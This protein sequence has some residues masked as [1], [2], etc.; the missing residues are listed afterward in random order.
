[1]FTVPKKLNRLN[2]LVADWTQKL[3]LP[4]FT[5]SIH[6]QTFESGA[7]SEMLLTAV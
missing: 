7:L 4:G 6:S 5:K 3:F 2:L 1:M